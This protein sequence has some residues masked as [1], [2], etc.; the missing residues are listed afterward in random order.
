MLYHYALVTVSP[1]ENL[2][3]LILTVYCKNINFPFCAR[4]YGIWIFVYK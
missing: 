3:G 4:I 2:M 1:L